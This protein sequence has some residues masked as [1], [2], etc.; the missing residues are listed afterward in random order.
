M[1]EGEVA[2]A[3]FVEDG[4]AGANGGLGGEVFEGVGDGGV[5]QVGDG[6][7]LVR[8]G[9][10]LGL[11]TATFADGAGHEDIGE[12]LH[13]DAFIAEALA[14]VAAAVAAIEGEGGGAEAGGAGGFGLG[15]E[16]ADEVPGL[17][18]KGGV[19]ARGAGEGGLIDEN[20]F[21]EG[22]VSR[23]GGDLRGVL[24]ELVAF[25]EQALVDDLV[26]EGGFSGAGYA[27][28]GDEASER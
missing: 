8:D 22:V 12:E 26:E 16:L 15:V 20:D 13:L 3:D 6:F 27:G 7:F 19:G 4:E 9:E 5:E 11:E 24:G 17:G 25:G 10:D 18:V 21:G 14:V 2:E 23:D 1:A 28:E